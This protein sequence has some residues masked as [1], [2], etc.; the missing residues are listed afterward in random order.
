MKK[1]KKTSPISKPE[2]GSNKYSIERG[3][4]SKLI[5]TKDFRL[6]KDLDIKSS[7]LTGENKGVFLYI[8]NTFRDTGEIPTARVI[9]QK[10]PGYEFETYF[11]S[12]SIEV[13]GTEESLQ[14]WCKE[15]RT[16][17]KHNEM[18]EIIENVASTLTDGETDKAYAELKKGIWHIENDIVQNDSVDITKDTEDRKQRYLE[19]KKNKGMMGIPTGIPHL[20]YMLKGLID[21]TLT[22]II[23]T[24]GIGKSW[25]LVII[26]CYAQLQGYRVIIFL[27]EMST[28]IMRDRCEAM[29][30]GML[31]GEFDYNK[32]KSGNLSPE[33]E[34]NYFDFLENVLPK[35]EPMILEN[36]T[37]VS[38]IIA[39]SEREKADLICVDSAYLMEDE[40]GAK[41]DW[42]RITHISRDLKK[43]AKTIHKPI[44]I[45]AQADQNT[46]KKTG[47][48]LGDIKYSQAIGQDSDN[49]I[50]LFRDEV[51]LNDREMGM[52][53]LKQREGTLGKLV[54]NWDFSIMNFSSIYSEVS[55]D[56]N[57][58][59]SDTDEGDAIIGMD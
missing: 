38:S 52:R 28:E 11:N 15:L 37:G 46:S 6:I 45:N 33:E 12:E 51:M 14:H 55:E 39:V 22:T 23:A 59:E 42:E 1:L 26:A 56:N 24:T 50:S 30:Y 40:Q 19:R 48:G 16:K 32:F 21:E 53:V 18:A 4:I 57:V 27:T 36:V 17:A 31:C 41:S 44:L 58:E 20:D 25:L 49:V 54:I 43:V 13:V 2:R 10:F 3:F 5:E 9:E 47:P 8:Q 35:L 34:E 29:L 7:F